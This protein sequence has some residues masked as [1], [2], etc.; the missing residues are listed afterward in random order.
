MFDPRPGKVGSRIQLCHSCRVGCSSGS[1][2]IPGPGTSISMG[3]A[4]KK[5][6]RDLDSCRMFTSEEGLQTTPQEK[7]VKGR[8]GLDALGWKSVESSTLG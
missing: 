8:G 2:S 7:E 5:G 1:D 6:G 4:I 3:V